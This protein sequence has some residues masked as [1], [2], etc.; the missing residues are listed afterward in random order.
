M[1]KMIVLCL[2]FAVAAG[3]I[4][5]GAPAFA[6]GGG[7]LYM[8]GTYDL[9]LLSKYDDWENTG[10]VTLVNPGSPPLRFYAGVHL[11]GEMR[12]VGLLVRPDFAVAG[13]SGIA[14]YYDESG[15]R[16][17]VTD[18]SL[19]FAVTAWI[20]PSVE[21]GE[22]GLLYCCLGPTYLHGEYR[23]AQRVEGNDAQSWDRQ[24]IGNGFVLPVLIGVETRFSSHFG[25]AVE[26]VWMGQQIVATTLD[27]VNFATPGAVHDSMLFPSFGLFGTT[28]PTFWVQLSVIYRF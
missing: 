11:F 27:K 5:S 28:G 15:S 17:N 8:P 13:E 19:L 26:G 6:L 3:S 22:A 16:Y 18:K 21:I 12:W 4:A 7:V 10:A 23:T 24:F 9:A 20:G 14:Y 25:L 1:R 2:L